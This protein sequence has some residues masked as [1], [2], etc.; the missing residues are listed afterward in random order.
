MSHLKD[1]F[2][3]NVI[4]GLYTNHDKGGELLEMDLT[5]LLSNESD[6][7][8]DCESTAES[9]QNKL[10]KL[11]DEN[12]GLVADNKKLTEEKSEIQSE[13]NLYKTDAENRNE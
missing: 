11:E 1:T 5:V 8:E 4:N 2:K 9:L 13:L 3:E 6:G 12:A 7:L 10:T